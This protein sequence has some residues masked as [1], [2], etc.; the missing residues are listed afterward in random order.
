MQ[1]GTELTELINVKKSQARTYQLDDDLLGVTVTW[2]SAFKKNKKAKSECHTCSVNEKEKRRRMSRFI[3][4][5]GFRTGIFPGR[6]KC[7]CVQRVHACVGA[8]ARV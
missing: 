6:G 2:K 5:P 8:P 4:C 3:T 7:T 1:Q